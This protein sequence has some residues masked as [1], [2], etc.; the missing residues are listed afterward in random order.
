MHN[1]LR[2]LKPV[3][4]I[5]VALCLTL[6]LMAAWWSMPPP[7]SLPTTSMAAMGAR[8]VDEPIQ[9]IPVSPPHAERDCPKVALGRQLFFD[10]ALSGDDRVACSSCHDLQRGGA[11]HTS[12]S[13]GFNGNRGTTNALSLFNGKYNIRLG[14]SGQFATFADAIDK[15]VPN[16]KVM[17]ITWPEVTAKLRRMPHYR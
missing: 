10:T 4:W 9:P 17:G 12:V 8:A 11:D 2:D 16:P 3:Y 15:I 14:W 5:G 7:F 6:L 1:P 13:H